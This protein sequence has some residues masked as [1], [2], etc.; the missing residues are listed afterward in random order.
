MEANQVSVDVVATS[1]VSVSLTLDPKKL[2][3]GLENPT[4]EMQA[5]GA[6][7]A[8]SGGLSTSPSDRG[9]GQAR[10]RRDSRPWRGNPQGAAGLPT[11]A[12]KPPGGW[13]ELSTLAGKPPGRSG[14]PCSRRGKP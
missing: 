6:G 8:L 11:L 5:R 7:G 3:T 10:A 12:G 14:K 13:R 4:G 2:P 1:E 9:W